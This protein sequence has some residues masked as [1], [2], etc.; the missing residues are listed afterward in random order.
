MRF[1][2]LFLALFFA[3]GLCPASPALATD[4]GSEEKR[5]ELAE[6][7]HE[8]RSARGQAEAAIEQLTAKMPEDKQEVFRTRLLQVFDVQALE[9]SSVEAMAEVFTA[10]ELE[11]MIDYFGSEEGRRIS[12]KMVIYQELVRPD[13]VLL[14]DEALMTIR[15][16]DP[17]AP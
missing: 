8:I 11:K 9:R 2:L 3:A 14:L 7:M 17:E 10:S 12:E 4:S 16:G 6:K 5:A 15:T 13:L 1:R